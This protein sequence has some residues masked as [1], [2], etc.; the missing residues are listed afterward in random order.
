MRERRS[1]GLHISL[2]RTRIVHHDGLWSFGVG[3]F[4]DRDEE[5]DK[6]LNS[7]N[8]T[9]VMSTPGEDQVYPLTHQDQPDYSY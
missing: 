3:I 2:E 4:L 9:S 5:V 7:L 1:E 8:E 6:W